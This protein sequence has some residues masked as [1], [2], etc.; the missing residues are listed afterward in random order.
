MLSIRPRTREA[1]S[2]FVVQIGFSTASTSSV[3]M[4]STGFA[5]NGAA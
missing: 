4:V 3:A 2:A 1:V 5:R